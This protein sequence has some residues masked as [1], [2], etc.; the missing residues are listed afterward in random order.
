MFHKSQSRAGAWVHVPQHSPLTHPCFASLHHV[1]PPQLE[2]EATLREASLA[3]ASQEIASLQDERRGQT[4]ALQ[5]QALELAA[6]E[7]QVSWA[8]GF[9]L[10]DVR[11][12]WVLIPAWHSS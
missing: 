8:K 6:Y 9:G 1:V 10:H 2:R 12:A 11:Q 4:A 3:S 7:R 5:Q